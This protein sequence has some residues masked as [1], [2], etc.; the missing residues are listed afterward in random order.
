M[1]VKKKT[2]K[3]WKTK[4]DKVFHEYVRRRDADNDS[5]YCKCISCNKPIHFTESDSGHFISRAK[6]ATRYDEQNVHAQCRKCN[7]FEYGRQ[8]EYSLKIGTELAE[9]LLIKSRQIYKMS[10]AEWLEV[11]EEFRDKLKAIKDIQNF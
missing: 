1:A 11:F 3:Y 2:Q 10:D 5:G 4:I 6:M 8:F 9:E 7:R